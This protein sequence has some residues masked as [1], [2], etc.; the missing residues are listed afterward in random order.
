MKRLVFLFF[1]SLGLIVPMAAAVH[2]EDQKKPVVCSECN[3]KISEANKKFSVVL[4]NVSGMGP[5][6]YDDVGCAVLS[7]NKECATRQMTF[8]S[9]AIAYDYLTVEAVP[10]EKAFFAFK[11]DAWTPMGYGI[12]AFKDKAQAETFAAEHGKGKVVR[13]FELVDMMGK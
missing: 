8:D 11:S 9:N 13:W 12:V 1:L 10:V 5:S 6:F 4:P 2:A 7:R 3:M